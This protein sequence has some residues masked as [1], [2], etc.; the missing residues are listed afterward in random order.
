M[1]EPASTLA[2]GSVGTVETQY[3]DLP[4]PVR[5][6]CG[7]ELFPVRVAYET[8]GT[9]SPRRDNVI[10]AC[11]AL[12]G[13]AHAAGLAKTPPAESTRD[14]FGATDR[15][16]TAGKGLGWW[17]GMIGPGKAFDTDRFY[18]VSTNLLGGCRGTTGPSSTDPATGSPYGP[19]FPVITV[20]DMVRTERAFLHA[21]G[22]ERLAA[23]A[24]GS[25]GG[26]Q[27]FEWAIL[28]PDQVD[29]VVAI[30]ATH[31]L[32]P[33]G[34]AWNAIARESIMR[35]PAWQGGRYYG[36]GRAPDAGMGVA[37]MV[38]HVTYL[39]GQALNDKF[40]RRLQFADDVRFT[41][42]E[43]EFAV[44]SYLRHQAD[45][46]VRR[47]DANT[48]LYMSRALTYFDL[49][50]QHGS[51]SLVQALDGVS[52][53]TLLIAFSSDW[54]YPP[55]ASREIEVALRALGKPAEVHV[56]EE[57][58][59]SLEGGA[60]AVAFAS[61]L[62]AQAAA[63]FTLLE[64]G[65][66]VVSSSAL[67]GGTVNQFKHVLRKMN[68]E[69]TWVDP[70]DPDAWRKEVRANTKAFFG[71]TIGNPAGNVLDIETLAAIAHEHGLPLIV[72]NTFATPYL[73][74]PIEWGADIV[75]HSA[76]K[77]IG[78]HGTS[79]GGVVVE[80]GT[81]DWSNGRFPVVADPSPA[82]HG[83]QFHETFGMYGYLMKL[84]AETLRDLGAAMS[85]F[86]AFLFLQGLET[87]SLRMERHVQNA[88]AVAAFLEAHER[89][90]NTTYPGLRTSR[91]RPLVD[92][93]LPHGAGAVFSFDCR[94][95][96][97]AGQDFIRGVSLWSHLANVGDSKSLIIHPASTT[98]RQLNDD[99][100]R[101]AGVGP[102][103]IR[104][105]VGTESVDDLIWD[106]EQGFALV[107]ATADAGT[108]T[109]EVA[110]A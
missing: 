78:G 19:D 68:V 73:C 49:A 30:A 42:T 11:H 67:Y 74:R 37:R 31:A 94:G 104:L 57:R 29:A 26:M 103:T 44:E 76:T 36:T 90:S 62:A 84:R 2:A 92:K 59:A 21:L 99:E 53:R 109:G 3:L 72:D 83:L 39:S 107:A 6:D 47:F 61:G 22:I 85:P 51:G 102:G 46:F 55:S 27:A 17:D 69:L 65:D 16:G 89:A 64:P 7:R 23:V 70:D 4:E 5:L 101:A 75:I 77:F 60:G 54:L 18:V 91:Y 32:H 100:L 35:D 50:R 86:N 28:F 106:L 88:Q 56:I 97:A 63:L 82:Y 79:I 15:D 110:T 10:L 71:E 13:D 38:G 25:L 43:P 48:Y 98:H 12:S 1:A 95:G 45:S 105:S 14:G 33:Q 96:R 8:Y 24:G 81:F 66:H 93:Y 40:G 41:I 58:V 20:A 108:G 87:L 52:A 80:A 34:V 9:L